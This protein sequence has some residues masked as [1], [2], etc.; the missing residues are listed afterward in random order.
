MG[1]EYNPHLAL[2]WCVKAERELSY[3]QL[4][5]LITGMESPANSLHMKT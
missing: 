3:Q 5:L 2:E 4:L 1:K